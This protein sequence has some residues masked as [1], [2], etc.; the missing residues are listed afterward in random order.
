MKMFTGYKEYYVNVPKSEFP[1]LKPSDWKEGEIIEEKKNS[2][3]WTHKISSMKYAF[4][5]NQKRKLECF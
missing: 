1:T 4:P 3:K 5:I 2:K